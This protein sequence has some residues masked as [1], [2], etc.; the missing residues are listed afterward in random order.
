M[1]SESVLWYISDTVKCLC[2]VKDAVHALNTLQSNA[3]V[4]ETLKATREARQH[5]SIPQ[6]VE[7]A[8]RAGV[9]VCYTFL[10]L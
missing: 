6:T 3:A 1:S 8:Q 9:M 7:M 4:I 5:L 10:I 2:Y